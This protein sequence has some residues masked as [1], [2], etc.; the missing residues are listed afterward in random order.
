MSS[1]VNQLKFSFPATAVRRHL[2]VDYFE[3]LDQFIFVISI[4]EII[5]VQ[6]FFPQFL[7]GA[8]IDEVP[9]LREEGSAQK[10][11]LQCARVLR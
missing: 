8:K 7:F 2:C 9:K 1:I 3:I 4:A 5:L 6:I 11:P 10:M